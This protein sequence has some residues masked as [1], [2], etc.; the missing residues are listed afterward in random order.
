M[1]IGCGLLIN[2]IIKNYGVEKMKAIITG[3]A[4]EIE[5]ALLREHSKYDVASDDGKR[6]Y[7]QAAIKILSS[8]TPCTSVPS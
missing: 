8:E 4:N 2:K 5:F 1:K 6:Q 7:L 3:A